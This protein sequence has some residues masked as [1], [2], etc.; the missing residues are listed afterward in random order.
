M[1]RILTCLAIAIVACIVLGVIAMVVAGPAITGLFNS[2]VALTETSTK[3]MTALKT[4][5]YATAFGL[6]SS[7][8]QA[9]FG[10]SADGMKDIIEKNGWSKP[11]SWNF[12]SF[13]IN[14]DQ[15]TVGGD[16]A[17][18]DGTKKALQLVLAKVG[19]GWKVSGISIK[20][21]AAAT[22]ASQ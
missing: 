19:D 21:A 20:A 22:A 14:N 11:A 12:T 15:G 4:E 1:R 17:W 6:I 8:Q 16:I 10:G 5:D 3:F 2:T 13:N 7:D 9:T 18:S